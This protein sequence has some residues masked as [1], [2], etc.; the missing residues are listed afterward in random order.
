MDGRQVAKGRIE[1]TVPNRFSLDETFDVGLDTG[2]PVVEDYV[3]QMPFKFT[4]KINKVT[5]E[6]R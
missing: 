2:T 4:G 1:R 3:G 6:V 5:V